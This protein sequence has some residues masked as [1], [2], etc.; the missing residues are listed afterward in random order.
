MISLAVSHSRDTKHSELHGTALVALV[1]ADRSLGVA[2]QF[3]IALQPFLAG[4]AHGTGKAWQGQQKKREDFGVHAPDLRDQFTLQNDHPGEL[5]DKSYIE[6]LTGHRFERFD[7]TQ[8]V[9]SRAL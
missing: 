8:Q 9:D 3:L 1:H 5:D 7:L 2:Q 6:H 4:V